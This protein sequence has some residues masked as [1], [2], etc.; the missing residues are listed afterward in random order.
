MWTSRDEL[1]NI[2]LGNR[3]I[4][5]IDNGKLLGITFDKKLTRDDH[6]KHICNQANSKLYALARISHYLD[7]HKTKC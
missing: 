6:I 3:I 1:K 5:E 7:E 4:E 2:K